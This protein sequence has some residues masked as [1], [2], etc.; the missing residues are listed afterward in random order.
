[1]ISQETIQKIFD[2]VQIEEVIGDFVVLKKS[3]SNLKGL[4]P[5]TQE[6]HPPLRFLQLRIS[7]KILVLEKGVMR[8][9]FL[10]SMSI[11]TILKHLDT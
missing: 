11:T 10:W 5:F 4:S 2:T 7:G 9:N 8:S 1:M 6:K 3:G